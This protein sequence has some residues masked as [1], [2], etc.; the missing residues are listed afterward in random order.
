MELSLSGTLFRASPF[1][2]I[3]INLDV[4]QSFDTEITNIVYLEEK[5]TIITSSKGKL[6]KVWA[7]P[8]E[9]RDAKLVADQRK[10]AGKRLNEHNKMK[11]ANAVKK[12]ELSS[13]EDDLAGWHLD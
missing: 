4:L 1:V 3:L 9:W 7:L 5:E 11:V 8:K 2:K 10:Q 13:D 6:I 12:A